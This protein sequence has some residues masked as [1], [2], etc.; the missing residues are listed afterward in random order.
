MNTE[1]PQKCNNFIRDNRD[2]LILLGE[3]LRLLDTVKENKYSKYTEESRRM[4]I[5]IVEDW[6]SDVWNIAFSSEDIYE[7]EN[8]IDRIINSDPEK[9]E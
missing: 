5:E 7:E 2:V 9:D 6:I 1:L 3:K 4:A 8:E